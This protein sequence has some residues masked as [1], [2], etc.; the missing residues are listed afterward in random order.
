MISNL[1]FLN[2]LQTAGITWPQFLNMPFEEQQNYYCA[3]IRRSLRRL[4][5]YEDPKL[6][7]LYDKFKEGAKYR[8]SNL[9]ILPHMVDH[10]VFY[11]QWSK[12]FKIKN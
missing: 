4:V 8:A 12:I 1:P 5:K 11:I 7:V 9:I 6:K 3:R 2:V 10:T